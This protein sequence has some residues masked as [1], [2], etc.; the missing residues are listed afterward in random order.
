MHSS[1]ASQNLGFHILTSKE[2]FK[3]FA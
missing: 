2:R 1:S 3:W